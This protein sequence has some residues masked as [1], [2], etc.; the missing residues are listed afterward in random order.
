MN[1]Q[2]SE[3]QK[4]LNT[5]IHKSGHSCSTAFEDLF[6]QLLA[7]TVPVCP[8]FGGGEKKKRA[9]PSSSEVTIEQPGL[10]S[11]LCHEGKAVLKSG[12]KIWAAFGLHNIKSLCY[13]SERD[14]WGTA[15]YQCFQEQ[16][17]LFLY[18]HWGREFIPLKCDMSMFGFLWED[19]ISEALELNR[20]I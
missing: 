10:C 1:V 7:G 9:W 8:F 12:N 11:N 2:P 16:Q 4:R 19:S 6:F 5:Q 13:L 15:N 17:D 18:G 3:A 20:S 14:W